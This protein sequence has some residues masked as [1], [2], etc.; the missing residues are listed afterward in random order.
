MKLT[1]FYKGVNVIAISL[2][3]FAC[4]QSAVV[5]KDQNLFKKNGIQSYTVTV[6]DIDPSGMDATEYLM[7]QVELDRAGNPLK[8]IQPDINFTTVYTYK[9]SLLSE[10]VMTNA[11]GVVINTMK[12]S[13]DGNSATE[14]NFGENDLPERIRT[15]YKD[16]ENRDTLIVYTTADNDFLYKLVN[17]YDKLGLNESI[18]YTDDDTTYIKRV[19]EDKIKQVFEATRPNGTLVYRE[20]KTYDAKG[21]EI[22]YL[23]EGLMTPGVDDISHHKKTYLDNGLVDNVSYFDSDGNEIKRETYKYKKFEN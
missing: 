12:M 10:S 3:S 4:T 8:E 21:N 19:G 6:M 22:E 14:S 18:M 23:Y 9:D 16:N 7:M 2:L 11:D 1:N 13:Y 15:L 17:R 5:P 20:T